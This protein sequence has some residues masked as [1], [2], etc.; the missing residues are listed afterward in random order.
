MIKKT[1]VT[2]K[3][4]QILLH[5]FEEYLSHLGYANHTLTSY[6]KDIYE[7]FHYIYDKK[8]DFAEADH[9][10]VREHLSELKKHGLINATLARHLS[11]IKKF[12]RYL[13]RNGFSNKKRIALM[14][15]PKKEDKLVDVLLLSDIDRILNMDDKGDFTIF[16]DK[17]M[18]LFLYATGLRVSEL[19]SITADMI[20]EKNKMLRITGKGN[21]E[22]EVPLLD[23]VF[24]DW[25]RYILV[26]SRVMRENGAS[27]KYIFVN[28]FGQPISDRSIRNSMK[29]LIVESNSNVDFSPHTLRHTFATHLLDNEAEIRGIQELLGHESIS[30]TQ[31][32]THV[33]TSKL[34]EVYKRFHPH[35]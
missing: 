14:H 5:E 17:L 30:T 29:R 35:S 32:Y 11:S 28:R 19:A 3:D 16:R 9:R 34:F 8:I 4:L 21:K 22:R 31:K 2:A 27:H 26:R 24:K 10:T 13:I 12:Y 15:T 33:T 23:I 20:D 18:L 7:Y 25:D 6:R 1:H